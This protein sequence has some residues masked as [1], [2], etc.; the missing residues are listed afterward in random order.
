MP[1]S[2]GPPRNRGVLK[3]AHL[4]VN[5]REVNLFYIDNQIRERIIFE[6]NK[7]VIPQLGAFDLN[8][9][10]ELL[11][12][13][14]TKFSPNVILR[15][16]YQELILPNLVYVGG[17]GEISYWL[18]LKGVFDSLGLTYPLIQLRNS[19]M[20]IDENM[21]KKLD[22]YDLKIEIGG[23]I[24]TIDSIK[25][26]IDVGVEKVILGSAAIK[27]KEFKDR[28]MS[29]RSITYKE[30]R[31]IDQ[32]ELF[33]QRFGFKEGIRIEDVEFDFLDLKLQDLLHLYQKGNLLN[34]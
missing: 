16:V 6:E 26:Y 9:I 5:S 22:K 3:L 7:F 24:R 23:G 25:K 21:G 32:L 1:L 18:Q 4:Q 8:G 10:I 14:P 11:K 27:N 15:P 33:H 20:W 28:N 34:H 31:M 13:D 2:I 17:G 29:N 19:V 30:P 12:K